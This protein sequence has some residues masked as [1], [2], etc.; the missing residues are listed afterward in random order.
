MNTI[1]QAQEVAERLRSLMGSWPLPQEAAD[2]IDLLIAEN[3]ELTLAN[4][5]L[6]EHGKQMY[7]ELAAFK[8]QEPVEYTDARPLSYQIL[9]S[10][11]TPAMISAMATSKAV[12]SEGEFPM[13]M[14]L[15]DFSGE[16]KSHTVL[17]AA[18]K[19]MLAAAPVH[20]LAADGKPIERKPLTEPELMKCIANAGCFGTVKMSFESGPYDI[21]RPSLNADKL[22]RAI[23]AAH[24]IK[25]QA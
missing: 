9:P 3:V 21:D 17:K 10:E 22:C 6:G 1:E 19:A 2:F 12:D 11:P 20:P 25:E 14:D 7:A 4:E 24:G 16:N 15:L 5:Q 13:M 23:E 8:S 18:Y